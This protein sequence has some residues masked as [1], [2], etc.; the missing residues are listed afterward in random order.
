LADGA[1]TREKIL[2]F[3]RREFLSK[4]YQKASLR[5]IAAA[6]G[7]TTGAIYT[8]FKDK[9]ALFEAI[10]DPVCRQ[11]EA[12]MTALSASYFDADADAWPF[13]TRSTTAELRRVYDFI[14]ANSDVFRLLVRGAAGSSRAGFV[15]S[16]VDREVDL[17][18]A[19]LER[20]GAR[21]PLPKGLNR[22]AIHLVSESYVNALL[23]P[24]RHGMGYEEAM[25][26]LEF[27]SAFY[28][29]GWMGVF[30]QLL[31]PAS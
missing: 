15:H 18:I 24:V 16:I 6:A 4:G 17:T 27:L 13:T 5:G 8:Y 21:G 23:E 22:A 26:N 1:G 25:A 9:N 10:V 2:R 14:Y 7:V 29:S 30:R 12:L 31:G 28:T 3:G 20:T 11:T 19:Y